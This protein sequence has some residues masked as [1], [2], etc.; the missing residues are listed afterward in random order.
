MRE[1]RQRKDPYALNKRVQKVWLTAR[2]GSSSC[3]S[4]VGV[5]VARR[6]VLEHQDLH[7]LRP[8]GLGGFRMV[9]LLD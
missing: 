8:K 3:D 2:V 5:V 4:R 1:T 6:R 9:I 7:A